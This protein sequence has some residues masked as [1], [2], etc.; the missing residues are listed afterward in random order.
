MEDITIYDDLF[1]KNEIEQIR[2]RV[3]CNCPFFYGESDDGYTPPVGFVCDFGKLQ[4]N[5]EFQQLLDDFADKI[6]EKD[7][8]IKNMKLRRIYL[9]YFSPND[10]PYFHTDGSDITTCMYY[11]NPELSLDEGGETQ[12]LINDEIKGV[13]SKPGRLVIF[14]GKLLHRATSFLTQARLTLVFKFQR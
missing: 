12:F 7:E 3:L 2:D 6:Y 13:R 1:T 9:N 4:F 11:L 14:D 5:R 10:N 8:K